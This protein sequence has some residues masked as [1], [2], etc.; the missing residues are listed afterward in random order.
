MTVVAGAVPSTCVPG[1][2]KMAQPFFADPGSRPV[3]TSTDVIPD[4]RVVS[5]ALYARLPGTQCREM[6]HTT[7]TFASSSSITPLPNPRF[8]AG[9]GHAILQRMK[10]RIS[11]VRL[12][13]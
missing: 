9:R 3:N 10:C 1:R 7:R 12:V 6:P 5:L 4:S 11:P 8:D 13:V 2:K